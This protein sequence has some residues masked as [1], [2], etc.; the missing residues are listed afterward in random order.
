MLK[1]RSSEGS[2]KYYILK[3]SRT[4]FTSSGN[5]LKSSN[6]LDRTTEVSKYPVAGK[7]FEK[8]GMKNPAYVHYTVH[9]HVDMAQLFRL[10][11]YHLKVIFKS[12]FYMFN[13]V[14]LAEIDCGA[15]IF[16]FS[17]RGIFPLKFSYLVL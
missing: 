12:H 14:F 8:I 5:P 11:F 16:S 1:F 7:E 13:A 10:F 2:A 3:K 15:K 9:T 6:K 17:R 4:G